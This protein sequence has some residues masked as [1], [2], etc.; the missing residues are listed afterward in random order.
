MFCKTMYGD[1]LFNNPPLFVINY[2]Y[3]SKI[4]VYC[5]LA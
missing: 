2:N 3:N 1:R 5:K 4:E